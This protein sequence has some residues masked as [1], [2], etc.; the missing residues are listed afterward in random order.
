MKASISFTLLSTALAAPN[1]IDRRDATPTIITSTT[2]STIPCVTPPVPT[3][4]AGK[5]DVSMVCMVN[6]LWCRYTDPIYHTPSFI[7]LWESCPSC[8]A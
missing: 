3:Q 6:Y 2:T 1:A 5:P 8:M 7:P 4:C